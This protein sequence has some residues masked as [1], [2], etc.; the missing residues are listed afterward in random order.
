MPIEV[1]QS[2]RVVNGIDIGGALI[3]HHEDWL[4]STDWWKT[5]TCEVHGAVVSIFKLVKQLGTANMYL[6]SFAKKSGKFGGMRGRIWQWLTESSNFFARTGVL[7]DNVLFTDR[8]KGPSGK[9][10][11]ARDLGIT[12]MIDDQ[13]KNLKAVYQDPAGNAGAFIRY[14]DGIYSSFLDLVA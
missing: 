1:A 8:K 7:K 2:Q 14:Y 12:Y 3:Q 13:Y 4:G 9:G 10:L 5:P 6:I 11:V